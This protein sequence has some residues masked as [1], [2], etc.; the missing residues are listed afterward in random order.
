MSLVACS[1]C[2]RHVRSGDACPFCGAA[3][4]AGPASSA[5]RY[6]LRIAGAL[7]VAASVGC[8]STTS[9]PVYGAPAPPDSATDARSTEA[10]T[11]TA[12]PDDSGGTG[13]LYGAPAPDSG[14]P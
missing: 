13:T 9:T 5:M 10:A 1:A 6:P 12:G 14:A 11:D 8:S 2:R 3:S 7:A 4:V